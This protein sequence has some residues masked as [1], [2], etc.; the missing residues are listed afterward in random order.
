MK[1]KLEAIAPP[2]VDAKAEIQTIQVL[3]I[4]SG[5]NMLGRMLPYLDTLS[6]IREHGGTLFEFWLYF[7]APRDAFY[8]VLAALPVMVIVT[9]VY[10][11]AR[12][13][14]RYQSYRIGS[15]ADYTMKRLPDRKEYHR[16]AIAVPLFGLIGL[17]I[18]YAVTFAADVAIY[19]LGAH[20]YC[21]QYTPS[22]F[23]PPC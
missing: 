3:W 1:R 2:G 11:A 17:V 15:R 22:M 20:Y 18:V 4:L 10:L 14:A 8:P 6:F 16:R 12:L 23:I 7:T 9:L 21:P 13:I 5:L 19:Y